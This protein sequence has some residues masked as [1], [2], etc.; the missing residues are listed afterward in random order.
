[1]IANNRLL[2]ILARSRTL[3]NPERNK[4][5]AKRTSKNERTKLFQ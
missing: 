5:T 2:R 4:P 1:M 3:L